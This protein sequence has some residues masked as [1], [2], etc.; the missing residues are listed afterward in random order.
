MWRPSLKMT[1]TSLYLNTPYPVEP[2]TVVHWLH[3]KWFTGSSVFD[4]SHM[5]CNGIDLPSELKFSTRGHLG[6]LRRSGF[7]PFNTCTQY[8][9]IYD[10]TFLAGTKH[11]SLCPT[12]KTKHAYNTK[13]VTMHVMQYTFLLSVLYCVCI[14]CFCLTKYF[15]FNFI[16]PPFITPLNYSSKPRTNQ[17]LYT[18]TGTH[19]ILLCYLTLTL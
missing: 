3:I 17:S 12:R 11:T 4:E 5:G 16:I 7:G 9:K 18:K 6:S 10:H 13:H 1:L 8:P 15:A 2:Q 19:A 14:F